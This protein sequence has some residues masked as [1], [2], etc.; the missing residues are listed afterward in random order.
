MSTA[1]ISFSPRVALVGNPNSGKTALF[2]ALTGGRAKVANYPGVTVS[3]I[4]GRSKAELGTQVT[5]IDLPGVNSV[6]ASS[7]EEELSTAVITGQHTTVQAD[8]FVIVVDATQLDVIVHPQSVIH[9]M[10]E[11]EDGSMLAQLGSPDMRTPIAYCLAWPERMAAP[12]ER[13][14]LA[15]IARLDFEDPD[16]GRFPCLGLAKGAL[17]DGGAKP[18]I[19]NAANEV[20]VAAFLEGQIGFTTIAAVVESVLQQY[21]ATTPASIQD[22]LDVDG[23]ARRRATHCL[24]FHPA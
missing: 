7:P 13:L 19:L 2:N 16:F 14:D 8:V 3:L 10:V 4:Q 1:D 18:A 24:E 12:V 20:A 23:E 5:V 21:D 9:S 11:Y 6:Y 15:R 22:V 17:S